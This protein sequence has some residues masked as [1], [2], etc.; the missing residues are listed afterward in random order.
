VLPTTPGAFDESYNDGQDAFISKLDNSLSSLLASTFFGGSMSD[1]GTS[2]TV[3]ES[4][5]VYLLGYTYSSDLPITSGA[6]DESY[7]GDGD[8]FVSQLDSDLTSLLSS[9][10]VGGING[11]YS[12]QIIVNE[13]S[14]IYII[15]DTWSSDYPTTPGAFDESYNGGSAVFI[16]KL[17]RCLSYHDTDNDNVGDTC[18]NCPNDYNPLQEDTDASGVGDVCNDILDVDGDEWEEGFDNCPDTPN[19]AQEDQYP[20]QGNNIGDACDC[21]CDF[22]CNG[23]VDATDVTS[24]LADFGRSEFNDPCTNDS[25][26]NGDVD[27]NGSC[28]ADDV[29]MFLQDFGRSQF[30]NPCP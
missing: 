18:D 26:C 24:F 7:N 19:P 21:E 8:V 1:D 11:D 17:D 29:T 20:P 3:D 15:G 27:C 25:P 14:N 10:F 30:F 5:N 16:S 23:A 2:I 12:R 9:T 28:D 6:F 13:N 4:G 22:D